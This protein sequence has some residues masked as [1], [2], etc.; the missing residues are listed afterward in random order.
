MQNQIL[1]LTYEVAFLPQS[2]QNVSI[3]KK[4]E[5]NNYCVELH[6]INFH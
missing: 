4:S 3:S 1:G 2:Y 6:E 5:F